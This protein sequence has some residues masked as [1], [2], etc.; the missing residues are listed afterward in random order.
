[1]KKAIAIALTGIVI[2]VLLNVYY[3]RDTYFWQIDTQ[4]HVL[5]KEL[6]L[7]T[8]ELN[9]SFKK[10]QTNVMLLLSKQ[11]LDDFFNMPSKSDET[12]KRFE[13]LY[14]RYSDYLQEMRV[15]NSNGQRFTMRK[16]ANNT[17]VTSTDRSEFEVV[18]LP[19]TTILPEKNRILLSHPLVTQTLVFGKVEFV[20]DMDAFFKTI[21]HSFN[22]DQYQFQW[23]VSGAGDIVYSTLPLGNVETL[24]GDS[25]GAL[26][27]AGKSFEL[28]HQIS[29]KGT[30]TD[31]LTVFQPLSFKGGSYFVAFSLPTNLITISIA[32]N[33]FVVGTV[34]LIIVLGI[35]VIFV[36]FLRQR[37]KTD[38]IAKLNQEA[39]RKM[40]YYLPAGILLIDHNRKIVSVNRAFLKLFDFEDEDL[41]VGHPMEDDLVFSNIQ[42]IAKEKYSD[43]SYKFN[44]R[45]GNNAE[46]IVLNEKIPYYLE[47]KRYLVDVYTEIPVLDHKMAQTN[48]SHYAQTAFIA[49]ISHELRTPLN[50]IIGMT[51]L[52]SQAN[53]PKAESDMIGI[54]K[55]SADT[56]LSLIND[57]LD[58]SKIESGKFDIES[59]PF[60]IRNEF[61]STLE[62][63]LPLAR[64]K[65]IGLAWHIPVALPSDFIGDPI[66]FR[67][68]LNNLLSNALKFTEKGKVYVQV[69]KTR[70]LNGNPGLLF[71]VKDTGIGIAKE[72]QKFIFNS[73]YQADESSTRRFGGT[74]LG[75]T[76]S[77]ELVQL[78]GGEI[79]VTSPCDLSL[80]SGRPGSEFCFTLPLRSRKLAKNLNT[81]SIEEFHQIRAM[82]VTDDAL[83]VQTMSRNLTALKVDFRVMAPSQE[84]IDLLRTSSRYHLVVIDNRTDFSGIDFLQELFNHQL[85]RNFIILFQSSDNQRSNTNLVKRLGADAYLRKPVRLVVLREFLFNHFPGLAE[86]HAGDA[87]LKSPSTIKILVAEDNRLNQRVAQSLFNKLGY[88]IDLANDG[89]D[90]IRLMKKTEYDI[91]FMDIYMPSMDGIEAVRTLKAEGVSCPIIAMTASNDQFERL[92][93]MEVGMDDYI[94]K[95]TRAEDIL[96]MLAKWCN[97]PTTVL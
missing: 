20:I 59:I 55:R 15:I 84:T 23:V 70:L 18:F 53:F 44:I 2:L 28:S 26:L 3:Y 83:Q 31:V 51:D 86:K 16:G 92:R 4:R 67:Q 68:V 11:E 69:S 1:M 50:G 85:H 81:S 93:A 60:D 88:Q 74:G 21:F 65:H 7:C 14:S 52:L 10:L 40:I 45:N 33:A 30:N 37:L 63:F 56:L 38:K 43:Y 82:L 76:I 42:L 49:N 87:F 19:T 48:A 64:E 80:D 95:P 34:S 77:K 58:F 5:K 25:F 12:A 66:R 32:R 75:T 97:K 27:K 9:Q 72:K 91:V 17:F 35:M 8:D 13:L 54:L 36:I 89:A 96:R 29:V 41:V 73:F 47:Q 90:A 71:S 6:L 61:E 46:T 22:L 57:I 39:L 79:W 62:G 94:S 78:M 24:K